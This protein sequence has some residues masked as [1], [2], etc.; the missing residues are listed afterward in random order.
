MNEGQIINEM[1]RRDRREGKASDGAG[2]WGESRARTQHPLCAFAQEGLQWPPQ[3][4]KVCSTHCYLLFSPR[5]ER[6]GDFFYR[7]SPLFPI[8]L[9][10]IY[11]L[12]HHC[13]TISSEPRIR[14]DREQVSLITEEEIMNK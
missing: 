8:H 3:A 13:L 7:I 6:P 12:N 1:G 5:K 14:S 10:I 2:G 11:S 4:T 9:F